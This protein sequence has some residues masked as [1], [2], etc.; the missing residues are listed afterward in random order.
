MGLLSS[1]KSSTSATAQESGF[2]EIMGPAV[3][4]N[5]NAGDDL[6]KSN[7]NLTLDSAPALNLAGESVRGALN[8]AGEVTRR[9][10]QSTSNQAQAFAS[11]L[12]RF[13]ERTT[14]AGGG[15]ISGQTAGLVRLGVIVAGAV[16]LVFVWRNR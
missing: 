7:V 12:Q 4:V 13:A 6:A 5:L 16:G 14:G 8:L 1:S 3:N 15:P 11:G 2:Q 9:S 10:Q